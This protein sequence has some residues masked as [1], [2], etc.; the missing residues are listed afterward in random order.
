[1]G[2]LLREAAEV[3]GTQP[4][5]TYSS[6]EFL[7][8]LGVAPWSDLPLWLPR[9]LAN[10]SRVNIQK[11]VRAGLSFRPLR[12]TISATLEW[13]RTDPNA[14]VVGMSAERETDVLRRWRAAPFE[15]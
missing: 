7:L 11:A 1:M 10:Q 14:L 12:E 9:S 3:C 8:S 5:F 15:A 4:T 13:V 2:E 6:Q